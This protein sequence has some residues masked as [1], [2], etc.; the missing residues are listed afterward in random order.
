[1]PCGRVVARQIY[2]EI[3]A[4]M[5][6]SIQIGLHRDYQS[7]FRVVAAS[8]VQADPRHSVGRS[9]ERSLD[10]RFPGKPRSYK[11]SVFSQFIKGCFILKI[12]V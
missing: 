1:M 11:I 10:F 12:T 2:R 7:G 8:D 3:T 9:A 5:D 6:E 4:D